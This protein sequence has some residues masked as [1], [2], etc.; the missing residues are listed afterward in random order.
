MQ[1]AYRARDAADARDAQAV[2]AAAGIT[3]HIPDPEHAGSAGGG[4]LE[5]VVLVDNVRLGPA[6]RALQ[7]WISKHSCQVAGR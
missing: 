4:K 6:R 3:S 2:L 1:I 5:I 7:L